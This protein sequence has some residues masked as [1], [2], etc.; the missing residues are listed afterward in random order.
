MNNLNF[1]IKFVFNI[2]RLSNDFKA[3]DATGKTG[4][5]VEQKMFKFKEDV[6]VF[7][8]ESK[9]NVLFKINADKWI[10]F[11]QHKSGIN[12]TNYFKFVAMQLSKI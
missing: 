2:T 12:S 4:A 6:S 8:N 5:F 9:S 7:E 11:I 10:D 1:P 3:T